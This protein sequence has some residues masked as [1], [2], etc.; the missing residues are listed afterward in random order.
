MAERQNVVIWGAGPLGEQVQYILSY[1]PL[2]RVR[3]FLDDDPSRA[4]TTFHG[5]PVLR[6]DSETLLSLRKEGVTHGIVA[7]GDKGWMRERLSIQLESSGYEIINAVHPSAHI[8]PHVRLGKGV[9]ILACVNLFF[10]PV[11]GNYVYIANSATVSHDNRVEDNVDLCTGCII[12]ARIHVQKNV[13][14]GVG[15]N[16]VT[17]H[18]GS[19]TVGEGALIGAGALVLH[20]VPPRAVVV[21]VPG[22]IIKY[23]EL[24]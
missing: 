18:T 23:R 12:G 7:I 3:A 10:N 15:A 1:N 2:L 20:D 4:G 21:G 8:S 13:F 11:I 5:E 16:V 14:V 17:P 19:I 24:E 22:R 6:P 9:I